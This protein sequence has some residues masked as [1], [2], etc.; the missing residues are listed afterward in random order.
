MKELHPEHDLANALID[1][2]IGRN[3]RQ[4]PT[5]GG[6]VSVTPQDTDR[7]SNLGNCWCGRPKDHDWVGKEDHAPHPRYPE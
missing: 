3:R 4:R 2:G 7:I 6:S 5:R 1:Q